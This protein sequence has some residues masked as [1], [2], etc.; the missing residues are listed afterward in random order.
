MNNSFNNVPHDE[1]AVGLQNEQDF[2]DDFDDDFDEDFAEETAEE[3][4]DFE[5]E[6]EGDFTSAPITSFLTE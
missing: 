5:A 4:A 2:L 6:Y 3:V 1:S